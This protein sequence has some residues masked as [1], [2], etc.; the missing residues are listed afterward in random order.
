[1][2]LPQLLVELSNVGSTTLY[3]SSSKETSLFEQSPWSIRVRVG[4]EEEVT[5][6]Y[7]RFEYEY[8]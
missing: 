8:Q 6:E 4:S 2:P 3:L 1:M 7:L 5:R